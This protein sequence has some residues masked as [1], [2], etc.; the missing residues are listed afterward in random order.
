MYARI[1]NLVILI[2]SYMVYKPECSG[3]DKINYSLATC[4]RTYV[5]VWLLCLHSIYVILAKPSIRRM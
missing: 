3:F 2:S 4:L 1:V 5:C